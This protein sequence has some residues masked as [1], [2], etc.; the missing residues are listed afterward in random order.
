MAPTLNH[1][2]SFPSEN[3]SPSPKFTPKS[4]G[5]HNFNTLSNTFSD[6]MFRIVL[7]LFGEAV[8]V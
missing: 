3:K 4:G 2:L 7:F 1:L 6:L 5:K 8:F